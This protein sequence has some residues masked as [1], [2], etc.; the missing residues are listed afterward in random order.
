MKCAYCAEEI[1]DDAIKC[2]F[3]NEAIRGNKN[4]FYDYKKGDY[5][6]FS[7]ILVYLLGC[8]IALVILKYLI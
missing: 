7:K 4:A 2:R 8:I 1:N 5:T 6:N 3:C